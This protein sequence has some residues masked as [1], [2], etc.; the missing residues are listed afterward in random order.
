MPV[1]DAATD[2][3]R[4][5]RLGLDRLSP[6]AYLFPLAALGITA[7]FLAA[8]WPFEHKVHAALHGLC[9]Q[10]P[11]H[12]FVLGDRTLPFDARMTGIYA[13]FL[14]TSAYLAA[15]GR[16]RAFELPPLSVL[17][18]LGAFVAA[19][20]VD[21]T[22]ALLVD[23]GLW[24]PYAPDNRFRLVTGLLTGIAL[25]AIVCFLLSSTLWRN[26]RWSQPVIGGIGEL[27]I[28]VVLQIPFALAVLSEAAWLYGPVSI[29]L[30]ASATAV[31]AALALVVVVLIRGEDRRF[32]GIGQLQMHA[33]AALL[34]GLAMMAATAGARFLLE[35]ATGAPPLT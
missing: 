3:P 32:S 20:A 28:V 35:R 11:S 26:G 24:H 21:G 31:L 1:P 9:A 13:G 22:N 33:T 19:L 8:P 12:S 30:L 27:T 25:G 29:A 15:R 2:R 17:T 18:T 7:C 34:L 6:R 14:L 4:L 10:R 16:Y 5:N 23:L